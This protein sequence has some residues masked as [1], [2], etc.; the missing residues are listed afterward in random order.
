MEGEL[1]V[2]GKSAE[3][4]INEIYSYLLGVEGQG[5]GKIDTMCDTIKELMESQN[6]QDSKIRRNEIWLVVIV[7]SLVIL[8]VIPQGII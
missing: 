3:E 7:V 8:G 6:K 1:Y 5:G 2:M 4:K